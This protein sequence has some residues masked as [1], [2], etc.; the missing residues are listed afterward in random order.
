M[1][2]VDFMAANMLPAHRWVINY[3]S[4]QLGIPMEE[5]LDHL[6]RRI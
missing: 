5:A 2:I 4:S 3:V 1:K 6:I